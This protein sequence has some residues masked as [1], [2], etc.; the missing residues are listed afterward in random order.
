MRR[1]AAALLVTLS[2]ALP[3]S[4]QSPNPR[5]H[6]FIPGDLGLGAL[7][8]GVL[9]SPESAEG[10]RAATAPTG[11]L[12]DPSRPTSLVRPRDAWESVAR[13]LDTDTRSPTG[14]RLSY[15]EVFTPSISPFKR[16]NAYDAVDELGRLVVRDPSLRAVRGGEVPS[17]WSR[18]PVARFTGEV[19]VELSPTAPTPIPSVGAEQAL[20]SFRTE[21]ETPVAFFQDS[22]GNLFVR[23]DTARTVRLVYVLDAPQSTFV[24]PG[25]PS[26]PVG[27]ID[28][29]GLA[30]PPNVP[31]FLATSVD[32]VLTRVGVQRHEPYNSLLPRLVEYFRRF[33]DAELTPQQQRANLYL[34]LGL[35][36]VGACR[37]RAYAFVLTLHALGVPA[38]YVGN[39]A[40]AW[41]EVVVP[42]VGW[43]RVDL[44]GWDIALQNDAGDRENFLPE[45]PD[46]FPR[47]SEYENGYSTATASPGRHGRHHR[48]RPDENPGATAPTGVVDPSATQGDLNA[49]APGTQPSSEAPGDP[50]NPG[51]TGAPT[52]MG[53]GPQAPGAMTN[54]ATTGVRTV[55]AG[56]RTASANGPRTQ[57]VGTTAP[58][59][60]APDGNDPPAEEIEL[61]RTTL[62][63]RTVRAADGNTPRGFVRGTLIVCEGDAR[64]ETGA[65]IADLPVVLELNLASHTQGGGGRDT[66]LGTTVTREDGRFEARVLLPL[67]LPAGQYALRAR[68]TG[69]ARHTPAR[70]E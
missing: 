64:D 55:A 42:G 52:T 20:V 66:A 1:V 16:T 62:A 69:D 43:S 5:L 21:P 47:P 35:G 11:F 36:G 24:M 46:P 19:Q 59:G 67:D 4:A 30:P 7:P 63:L 13:S 15:R 39:E 70:S 17:R 51:E 14:A 34:T 26:T 27:S 57:S 65:S 60:E 61:H 2:V 58:E 3:G 28:F 50:A 29:H 40:H 56:A 12:D 38:R 54:A 6:R 31:Q 33:R 37:H 41:A 44:G 32:A 22:A 9:A 8:P 18:T 53:A 68:T 45:N 25:V 23:A 49:G 48:P 10:M